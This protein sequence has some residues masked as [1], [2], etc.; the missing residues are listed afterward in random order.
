MNGNLHYS[1]THSEIP[2]IQS[3][4]LHTVA[5]NIKHQELFGFNM[6]HLITFYTV[7]SIFYFIDMCTY[8]YT[9]FFHR[10]EVEED[11]LRPLLCAFCVDVRLSDHRHDPTGHL[12]GGWR[13]LHGERGS[14]RHGQCGGS[15]RA[16]ELS[17]LVAG[18]GL[19]AALSEEEA[20]QRCQQHAQTQE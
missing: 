4:A 11:L 3:H 6:A 12:Q 20:T 7:L 5:L 2:L 19:S 17:N 1:P 14:D 18:G 8:T 13:E 15:G 10:K 16:S 9:F